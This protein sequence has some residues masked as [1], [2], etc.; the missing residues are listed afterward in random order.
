VLDHDQSLRLR[1]VI[2]EPRSTA[3]LSEA[4][5]RSF[6]PDWIGRHGAE[7]AI[8]LL[9]V[10]PS[11]S[12]DPI[13][14]YD[15]QAK[16]IYASPAVERVLGFHSVVEVNQNILEMVH[17]DDQER[18]V[19]NLMRALSNPGVNP[20]AVYRVRT[21]SSGAWR[22]LEVIATNCLQDPRIEGVVLNLR[23]VTHT[24]DVSRAYATFGRTNQMLLHATSE[25][26]L[27]QQTCQTII[28]VGGYAEAWIGVADEGEQRTVTPVASAGRVAHLAEAAI[29]WADDAR[30]QGPVGRALRSN[31]PHAVR[32]LLASGAPVSGRVLLQD[33]GLRACCAL[34]IN[35]G[36]GVHRVLVIADTEVRDF[37]DEELQL[38][39]ELTDNLALG[40]RELRSADAL[41]QS[42]A[43][44]RTLAASSPIGILETDVEGA[45]TYANER[46]AKIA[47]TEPEALLGRGWIDFIEPEDRIHSLGELKDWDG[48]GV[49]AWKCRIRTQKGA[50]RHIQGRV[51][52]KSYEGF[53]VTVT[54]VTDEVRAQEELTRLALVD[55]LTGL[56]NRT[57][58]LLEL[59]KQLQ[60]GQRANDGL[61]ILFL[62]LDHLKLINDSLGHDAGDAVISEAASR[63]STTLR[64]DELVARF[65]GDEFIFLVHGGI[66]GISAVSAAE[67]LLATLSSPFEVRGVRLSVSCSIGVAVARR[68]DSAE[69]LVR[70]AD[71]AMYRAK[72]QGRGR[73]VVFDDELRTRTVAR[74]AVESD[75]GHALERG[76]LELRYQPIVDPLTAQPVAAEAL[77]RW[78]HPD[79]GVVQPLEF[80]HVAEDLG[81]IADIG[82]WVMN[83]ATS[84]LARWDDDPS[85]PRLSFVA[86]NVS[87]RQLEFGDPR[88]WV[89]PA[90]AHAGIQPSRVE[91][92][93]TESVAMNDLSVCQEALNSLRELGI[94]IALDDFGTGYSS[95]SCLHSLPITAVKIDRS[96]IERLLTVDSSLPI[97]R[98]ILEM[99]HAM[100]LQVVA[101]GVS[102]EEIWAEVAS[103]GCDLAQGFH[104]ARPMAPDAFSEWSRT[105]SHET[106]SSRTS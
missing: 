94:A 14:V 71:T 19:A 105:S 74:L 80:I 103:L 95:L 25:G 30:G 27:F 48:Q 70:D 49:K 32:D 81:L 75:L 104:F 44:F 100:G 99:S 93:V 17:P 102:S 69:S 18:C 2:D 40:L 6:H 83:E 35:C 89:V 22:S 8:G 13:V 56:P 15:D 1:D 66:E 78:R 86:V 60:R 61:T 85:V 47:G 36:D 23:D 24:V 64:A 91:I 31:Q 7:Q 59:R 16:L 67:R 34:P 97:V 41:V 84:Q 37:E 39:L 28:E 96:F 10:L 52:A 90:I 9:R 88:S 20:P 51:A 46:M 54:D 98:A 65:G 26:E 79:R 77:L 5:S 29:S 45:V 76:E 11:T 33:A 53:V 38:F 4:E 57:Q 43:R 62:D 87:S 50:I 92:E 101:E 73:I 21:S 12:S 63:F 82:A 68:G 72:E 3:T 106:S 42:E 58:F 55:P